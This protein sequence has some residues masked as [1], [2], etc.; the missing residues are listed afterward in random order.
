[1]SHVGMLGLDT[2]FGRDGVAAFK[3]AL[4]GLRPNVKVVAEEYAAGNTADFAPF[5]ERLFNALKDKPGKKVI[6]FIWAGPHPL[7]KFV[8]MKPERFGI[9]LAPG[10]NILPVMAAWRQFAGTEGGIY[11]YY[12]FPKNP[13][14]DWLKA[15]YQKRYNAPPDFFVAGGFAAALR[16]RRR[17][18]RRPAPPTPRS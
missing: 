12:D 17:R 1:M 11:Y 3:Q 10:G 4:A 8:D 13:M 15:E 14:N 5:A 7:A 18:C 9:E 2:A 6:G 16:G